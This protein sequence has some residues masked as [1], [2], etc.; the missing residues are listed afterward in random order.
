MPEISPNKYLVQAGWDDVPH[1]DEAAKAKLISSYM[2]HE[3]DA[4]SKGKPSLGAGAIYPI[5]ESE[6]VCRPFALPIYWPRAYGLDVG[7]NRTAAVWGAHDREVDCIYLY[8]EH[9]RGQAEPSIHAA[10]IKARGDWIPGAVDPAAR[11]RS[12]D[13]GA[14]LLTMYRDLALRLAEADNSVEAGLYTVWERLSTGRMKVFDSMRNWLAEY[15]IYRRDPKGRI[16]KEF[17]HAMDAT[18]YLAVTGIHNAVVKPV[19]RVGGSAK[20]GDPRAGY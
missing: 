10:A 19:P 11:G 9:Y 13:D 4:R 1:L 14:Q 16:I 6:I 8:A 15:R 18:R 20:R 12:V 17:D 5:E 2:P 7:W 3:R